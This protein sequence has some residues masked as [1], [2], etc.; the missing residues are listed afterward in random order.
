MKQYT[1][2]AALALAGLGHHATAA[3]YD[4][5][6]GIERHEKMGQEALVASTLFPRAMTPA[7]RAKYEQLGFV[8]GVDVDDV[9]VNA[10][11]P[12]GWTR[13]PS[14]HSLYS[15]ILDEKGRQRVIVGYKA[16]V[17]D[18]WANAR[19]VRRY[20]IQAHYCADPSGDR[21][22]ATACYKVFDIDTELHCSEWY[23]SRDREAEATHEQATIAWLDE[24]FP[25]HN[26]PLAYWD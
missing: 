5:P 15:Y 19:L 4:T 24:R 22:K 9:F 3:R 12:A 18:R 26:D 8:F 16:A 13:Q 21:D 11:M 6:G 25:E 2:P 17:Y 23:R 14:D 10:T 1:N 7:D 20:T